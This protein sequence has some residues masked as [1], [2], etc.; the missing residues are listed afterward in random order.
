MGGWLGVVVQYENSCR[1]KHSLSLLNKASG[2]RNIPTDSTELSKIN[3]NPGLIWQQLLESHQNVKN[4]KLLALIDI[5]GGA[6]GKNV[7]EGRTLFNVMEYFLTNYS[8][9]L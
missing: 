4:A 9:Q 3:Q 5:G 1:F 7:T 2:L 6:G 8:L